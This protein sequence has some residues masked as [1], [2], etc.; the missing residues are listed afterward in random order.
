[1][2]WIVATVFAL[3]LSVVPASAG[4]LHVQG[5]LKPAAPPAHTCPI[6]VQ[7]GLV[8]V[9]GGLVTVKC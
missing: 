3:S 9:N 4:F 1:M 8:T 6:V 2:N 5:F 7:G